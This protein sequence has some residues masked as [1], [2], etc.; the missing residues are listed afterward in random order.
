MLVSTDPPLNSSR[1][2]QNHSQNTK[3][4]EKFEVLDDSI[5]S[6][7]AELLEVE[8]FFMNEILKIKQRLK[9]AEEMKCTDETEHLMKII[10]K[11][12]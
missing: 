9:H 3:N 6:M 11:V 5:T 2:L 7:K 12:L 1:D 4:K 8:N 10:L